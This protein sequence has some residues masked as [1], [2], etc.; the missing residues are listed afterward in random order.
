MARCEER[1]D[2]RPAHVEAHGCY[3]CFAPQTEACGL[4]RRWRSDADVAAWV[5]EPSER[6]RIQ[7]WATERADRVTT[8]GGTAAAATASPADEP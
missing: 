1:H 8:S 5:A 4:Q 2:L 7:K 3:S 6:E